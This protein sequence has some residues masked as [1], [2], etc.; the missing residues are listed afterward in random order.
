MATDIREIELTDEQKRRIAELAERS[1]Q[2]WSEVLDERLGPAEGE[3]VAN[4]HWALKDRYIEDL[5]KW[6]EYF[7]VWLTR[8]K[9][10]NPNFDDSRESIYPD[11][12]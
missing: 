10:Y 1:G 12:V 5:E 4:T 7:D 9:S 11:R 2:S 8:R 6:R 3:R